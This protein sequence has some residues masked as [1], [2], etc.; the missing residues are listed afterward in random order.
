MLFHFIRPD[1]NTWEVWRTLESAR[2][3]FPT[4]LSCSP[5]FPRVAIQNGKASY[6]S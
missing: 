4:L 1:L 5:N 6:I 2:R 3:G